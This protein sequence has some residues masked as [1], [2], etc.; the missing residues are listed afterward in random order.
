M[1]LKHFVM[2]TNNNMMLYTLAGVGAVVVFTT[3][4]GPCCGQAA[5]QGYATAG[6][7]DRESLALLQDATDERV[8]AVH[9]GNLV[10]SVPPRDKLH[11]NITLDTR[12]DVSVYSKGWSQPVC[13]PS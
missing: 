2:A 9:A 6:T 3:F 4:L 7:T 12:P 10:R 1:N 5:A 11:E 13:F 8:R